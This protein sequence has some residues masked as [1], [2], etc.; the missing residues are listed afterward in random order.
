MST[1]RFIILVAAGFVSGCALAPYEETFQCPLSSNYGT[2]TNV[3]G[4]YADAVAAPAADSH[5]ADPND[6]GVDT[7]SRRGQRLGARAA[8]R[9]H[10]AAA[11]LATPSVVPPTLLRTWVGAY[12]AADGTLFASR[13]VFHIAGES[14]ISDIGHHGARTP[15]DEAIASPFLLPTV[16]R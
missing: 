2:C 9:P 7:R 5:S 11:E 3:S 4:A 12:Q 1:S 15:I 10:D 6:S 8:S 13:Y 14:T 16:P